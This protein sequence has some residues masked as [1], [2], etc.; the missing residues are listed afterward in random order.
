VRSPITA[1]GFVLSA[2]LDAHGKCRDGVKFVASDEYKASFPIS[3]GRGCDI[4]TMKF[5]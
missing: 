4:T 2:T 5:D 1:L 3:K